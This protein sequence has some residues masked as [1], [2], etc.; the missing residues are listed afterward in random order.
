[1]RTERWAFAE[2]ELADPAA[3]KAHDELL[4]SATTGPD[5]SEGIIVYRNGKASNRF[6]DGTAGVPADLAELA[7]A[8]EELYHPDL[9]EIADV[10]ADVWVDDSGTWAGWAGP[11]PTPA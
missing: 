3:C 6:A 7:E 2:S 1:M 9:D 5:S 4:A 11:V 8:D 10:W